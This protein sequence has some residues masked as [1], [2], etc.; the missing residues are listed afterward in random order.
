MNKHRYSK[1]N[2]RE[3]IGLIPAGGRASRIAPLPC[4]KELFPVGFHSIVPNNGLRPKVVSH[5][6]LEKMRLANINKAYFIL[7][8]GKWDIPAYYGDGKTLDMHLAYLMMDLPFG[9]PY[10][11]DQAFPFVGDSI[12]ALGFPDM[13]FQPDD[14]FVQL[15]AKQEKSN[16]DIVLGLFPALKP[17]KTDMVE[18]DDIGRI[19]AIK[20]KPDQTKLLY[21]WETAVWT[22][23]FTRFMHDYVLSRQVVCDESKG[24]NNPDKQKELHVGDIIQAAIEDNIKIDSVLFKNGSCLDI[25]TPDDL[26][27][28][29]QLTS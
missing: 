21:A 10:T 7:R 20:I 22:P 19:R 14:V 5:Y 17:H 16:A 15:L 23:V 4:S 28:A 29:V 9:V 8:E 26:L 18:I 6:L 24:N 11:L 25:G 2:Y 13:I 1:E 27:K 12:V 3:V